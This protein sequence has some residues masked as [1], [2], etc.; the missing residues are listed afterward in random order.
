MPTI[1]PAHRAAEARFRALVASAALDPP[2]RV[3]YEP[4][5]LTFFWDGPKVAVVVDLEDPG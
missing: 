1:S 3:T 5:S 4:A 2:D